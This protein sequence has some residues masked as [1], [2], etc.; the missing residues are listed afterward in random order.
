MVL[1]G[2][3]TVF[4]VLLTGTGARAHD[5]LESTTP[6]DGETL[7]SA[8]EALVLSYTGDISHL[9]TQVQVSGPDGVVAAPEPEV[10]GV[11]VRQPLPPDLPDGEYAVAWRVTSSDGHPIS[12]TFAFTVGDAAA[13]GGTAD[14]GESAADEGTGTDGTGAAA[15]DGT[16]DAAGP[17]SPA[18]STGGPDSPA[19]GDDAADGGL[20]GWV[21]PLLGLAAVAGAATAVLSARRR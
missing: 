9:G 4:L 12:G 2:L 20:P 21:W 18:T 11:Q 5:A 6:A 17:A 14:A 1:T 19:P 8:P 16:E 7:S 15:T 3:A 10:D 13:G